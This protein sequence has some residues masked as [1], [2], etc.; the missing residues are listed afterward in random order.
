MSFPRASNPVLNLEAFAVQS[1]TSSPP[2][3][4]ALYLRDGQYDGMKRS[5]VAATF[6]AFKSQS[7]TDRLALFFHGGLVDKAS[8]QQ[9]AANEYAAYLDYAF[10]LFFIWESG[11]SEVLAHH[12]PLIFA[13]TIFGRVLHHASDLITPKVASAAQ[14]GSTEA[15]DANVV[16]QFVLTNEEIDAFM[17]AVKADPLIQNEAVA[18]ARTSQGVNEFLAQGVTTESIALSPRTLLSPEVVSSIRGAVLQANRTAVGS[19]QNLEAVPFS[20]GGA[21]QAAFAIAKAAVP[22]ILNTIKRFAKGRDHG[23]PC[24][25][26]EEILRALYLAN[27]GSAMWEEMKKETEDAFGTDSNTFGGTAVVEEICRLVQDKPGT[28]IS[29]V[30]HSTG[31][32]YIGNFLVHM[33]QALRTQGDTTTKF[34]IILLAPANTTDF[35]SNTYLKNR[36]GGIRIFQMKDEVEQQDHLLTKDVGP[37][38]PSIL[39]KIYPRSLLYLVSGVCEYIEGQGGSGVNSLDGCD[40][41]ILGMDRFYQQQAIFSAAAYP[42]VQLV[43]TDFPK[44]PATPEFARVL[45]PTDNTAPPGFRSTALKHGNFPG[46]GPTIESLRLCFTQGL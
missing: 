28:K 39:G 14:A 2:A 15:V 21:L 34:D 11:F 44:P 6:G 7:A 25:L 1:P 46:D 20:I 27:F 45:S 9:S 43:R 40:M 12:L 18:I 24:T 42:S 35:F 17:E 5:D 10:P 22:V 38:D 33:D 4:N 41:P 32:V 36:I 37:E 23:M 19:A 3:I 13:E 8:G 30:G 16:P 31:G 29:L 26:V